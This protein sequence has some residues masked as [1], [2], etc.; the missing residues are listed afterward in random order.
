MNQTHG[1]FHKKYQKNKQEAVALDLIEPN[2][3]N[4]LN[5]TEDKQM[6]KSIINGKFL[7]G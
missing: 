3:F 7:K 4:T 5:F 6:I 1:N 2:N